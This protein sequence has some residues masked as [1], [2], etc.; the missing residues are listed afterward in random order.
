M[1]KW[2]V[3]VI[4]VVVVIAALPYGMGFVARKQ[5]VHLVDQLNAM[6]DMEVK[7]TAYQQGWLSSHAQFNVEI[8]D[9]KDTQRVQTGRLLDELDDINVVVDSRVYH[10]PLAIFKDSNNKFGIKLVRA[11]L[12]GDLTLTD[13]VKQKLQAK[14][15][16]ALPTVQ[17]MVAIGLN[18]SVKAQLTSPATN[19][20]DVETKANI[21]WKGFNVDWRLSADN[22]KITG[23]VILNGVVIATDQNNRFE[24][25]SIELQHQETK[26]QDDLWV[27]NA[28]LT[29]PQLSLRVK[30]V[31]QLLIQGIELSTEANIDNALLNSTSSAELARF[32][33]AGKQYGPG[34]FKLVFAN[35]SAPAFAKFKQQLQE[36]NQQQLLTP[37]RRQASASLLLQS[38]PA[39][40]EKGAKVSLQDF[41]FTTPSGTIALDGDVDFSGVSSQAQFSLQDVAAT[42]NIALPNPIAETMLQRFYQRILIQQQIAQLALQQAQA[43]QEGN[44]HKAQSAKAKDKTH[45]QLKTLQ[46]IQ[47]EAQELS[48]TQLSHWLQQGSLVEENNH[49][50]T[51]VNYK[52][53]QLYIN[54]KL[55]QPPAPQAQPGSAA[56]QVPGVGTAPAGASR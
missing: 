39:L 26:Q 13:A 24:L 3:V 34:N 23:S 47:S 53:K 16:G 30:G 45:G 37:Q 21:E 44:N 40:F 20:Q 10:G 17:A 51:N 19:F 48:K 29:L 33:V 52:N 18:G 9:V 31:E 36:I 41:K 55:V 11:L 12:I 1:R 27:G 28:R 2:L 15:S 43:E 54:G 56:G 5:I 14:F 50:K 22:N 4:A 35:I 32:N 42:F 7:I 25:S 38:A 6:P 8:S 49:Y 46:Q